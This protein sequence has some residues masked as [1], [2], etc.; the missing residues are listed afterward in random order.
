MA[1]TKVYKTMA[2]VTPYW[3]PGEDYVGQ[4]LKAVRGRVKDGDIVTVSEKALST[5]SGNIVDEDRVQPSPLAKFL[6]KYWM[7][8]AWAH[9]LGRLC[10]LRRRTIARFTTYPVEEGS[11][12]KQLAL[13]QCGFLQALMHGSEGGIDGSNLPYSFV[14][15]P[16]E[17]ASEKA[18]EIRDQIKSQLDKRVTVMII[19]TD[20]TYSFHNFHFTPRPRPIK[21]I[22]S[23][24]GVFAYLVGRFLRLRQR[25]TPIAIIGLNLSVEE[26]LHVAETANR[27]RGFGAG[28][29]VWDMAETFGVSLTDVTW[30]MLE[31]VEH[32]PIVIV[33]RRLKTH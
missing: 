12:H 4:I 9:T 18:E 15:L 10:H 1:S 13:Q 30:E 33:R 21:G 2:L 6:A 16:L 25:A 19:D 27:A 28:R 32:K 31:R 29:N 8:V 22:Q 23:K 7:R 14:S 5:A 26:A 20:K 11:R 3:R 24:G 17:N